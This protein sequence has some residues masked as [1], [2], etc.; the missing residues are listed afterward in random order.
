MPVRPWLGR[1]WRK[2]ERYQSLHTL[3]VMILTRRGWVKRDDVRVGD[4]TI[5]YNLATGRSQWT[6]ITAVRHYEDAPLMLIGNARW[7]ATVTPQH[8]WVNLPRI[9]VPKQLVTGES[10]HL[11]EWPASPALREPL[12]SC[13]ECGWTPA[14]VSVNGVQIHRARKHGVPNDLQL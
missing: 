11:C 6:R 3:D 10:C 9:S 12:A 13:P 4:E 5:G 1:I 8:M 14:S 7:H 2:L